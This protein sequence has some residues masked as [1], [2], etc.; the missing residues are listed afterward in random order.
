M[1]VYIND[2]IIGSSGDSEGELLANH[3]R[4]V[5]AVLD[6]LRREELVASVSITDFLVL[7]GEFIR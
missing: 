5:H 6:R 3:D 7:S 4:D 1:D 2:I